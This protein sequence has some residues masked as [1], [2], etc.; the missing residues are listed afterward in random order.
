M[1]LA[2]VRTERGY[3][4]GGAVMARGCLSGE[5]CRHVGFRQRPDE[6]QVRLLCQVRIVRHVHG[7]IQDN[8]AEHKQVHQVVTD[9]VWCIWTKAESSNYTGIS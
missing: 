3:V 7:N 6:P 4:G 5:R 8:V 1:L 9:Q 2:W